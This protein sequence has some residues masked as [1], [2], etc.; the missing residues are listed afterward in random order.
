MEQQ[1]ASQ[2]LARHLVA[3]YEGQYT[4]VERLKMFYFWAI[5]PEPIGAVRLYRANNG[6]WTAVS[7]KL[8]DLKR[9][10]R[11]RLRPLMI[12]AV[13]VGAEA[14]GHLPLAA[15]IIAGIVAVIH[16]S[17]VLKAAFT[18]TL[19]ETAAQLM[20]VLTI[21]SEKD[22][23]SLG[24]IA[25]LLNE[26]RERAGQSKVSDSEVQDALDELAA[27]AGVELRSGARENEYRLAD[28]VVFT[29]GTGAH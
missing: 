26:V 4:F 20:Y 14:L 16:T 25:A 21:Q 5:A 8:T 11:L 1:A 7:E 9:I 12:E 13:G 24:E 28:V 2:E 18:I 10:R 22:Y 27:C 6:T 23:L 3:K 19:A 29:K 17:H 15:E